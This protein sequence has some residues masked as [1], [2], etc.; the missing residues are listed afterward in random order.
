MAPTASAVTRALRAW[1]LLAA[2]R[3]RVSV[4]LTFFVGTFIASRAIRLVRAAVDVAG[5]PDVVEV[6]AAAPA[7]ISFAVFHGLTLRHESLLVG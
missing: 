4:T 1:W 5:G 6:T 2:G 7:P 3:S